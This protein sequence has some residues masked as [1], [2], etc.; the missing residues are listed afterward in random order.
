M[1]YLM[2][3]CFAVA[4]FLITPLP[5]LGPPRQMQIPR[6]LKEKKISKKMSFEQELQFIFNIKSQ[7]HS[8]VNQLDAL[9]FAI[10]RA[11]SHCLTN[12]RQALAL[13]T[14]VTGA[15]YLDAVQSKFPGLA[16]CANLLDVSQRSGSSI[17]DALAQV[18]QKM[19]N[20]RGFEQ[21][22]TTELASTK[23]TVFVLAGLP[24]LGA[25]MG[26]ML[27]ADSISWLFFTSAGRICLM[28]G[29]VLEITG[30]LWIKRLLARALADAQ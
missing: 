21:L 10:S 17:N 25:G 26:L 11:P 20:R 18:T 29:L 14:S 4:T 24:I 12:T 16:S 1:P 9:S 30:W 3:A 28:L 15:L 7:L 27:G 13:H 22:I 19:M 8:G 23:A 6:F 5:K 2:A